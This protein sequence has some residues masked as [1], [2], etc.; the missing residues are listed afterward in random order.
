[1][2]ES[3]ESP[4]DGDGTVENRDPRFAELDTQIKADQAIQE[5]RTAPT[6]KRQRRRS[7][8]GVPAAVR[9]DISRC[10]QQLRRY[11][12]LFI[13]DP[14]LRERAGRFLRSLLPPKRKRGRPGLATVNKAIMLRKKLRRQ[15]ANEKPKEIWK[16]IYPEAIPGYASMDWKRRK[17]ERFLLWKQVR[18]RRHR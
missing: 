13:A 12:K 8:P 5:R 11:R 16:R 6:P 1:M 9:K 18:N 3:S 17:A 4:R 14:K 7:R 2:A 10:A 15:Y